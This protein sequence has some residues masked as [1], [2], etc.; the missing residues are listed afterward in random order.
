MNATV[1]KVQGPEWQPGL[2]EPTSSHTAVFPLT[3]AATAFI[4]VHL[5]KRPVRHFDTQTQRLFSV[6]Q[7]SSETSRRLKQVHPPSTGADRAEWRVI[8][9]LKNVC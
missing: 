3:F 1:H 5:T 2:L 7:S 4:L 8:G 6:V 9:K